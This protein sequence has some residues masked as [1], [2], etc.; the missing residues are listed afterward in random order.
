MDL[1]RLRNNPPRVAKDLSQIAHRRL[2]GCLGMLLP[3][4]LYLFAGARHSDGFDP[5]WQ[6][7]GSISAYYYTGAVGIF[8]GVL[9]AL[10]LFLM[11]YRGY[12]GYV[13]DRVVGAVAGCAALGVALVPT[14]PPGKVPRL[15]WWNESFMHTHYAA[16]VALFSCFAL[17][18]LWLFR[19][20]SAPTGAMRSAEKRRRDA[21]YVAC[22]VAMVVGMLWAG[23]SYF[24]HGS[25]LWAETLAIEAF[26]VSWLVKGEA[27]YPIRRLARRLASRSGILGDEKHDGPGT[28]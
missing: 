21:I 16:A 8:T 26:A 17:F 20:T 15:P 9:F 2:I 28:A 24:T 23:S 19:K 3:V 22:G 18:S 10:S 25:I 11:T 14:A 12:E 6:L 7:L 13:A 1:L 27:D 5:D 4:L